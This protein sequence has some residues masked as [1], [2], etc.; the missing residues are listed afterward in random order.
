MDHLRLC[1]HIKCLQILRQVFRKKEKANNADRFEHNQIIVWILPRETWVKVKLRNAALLQNTA[2][3]SEAPAQGC[4]QS[5]HGVRFEGGGGLLP[6][7]WYQTASWWPWNLTACSPCHQSQG[8]AGNRLTQNEKPT[9]W[10]RRE[11]AFAW[12]QSQAWNKYFLYS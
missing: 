4:L 2:H 9:L 1:K 12:E 11:K 10:C 7:C 6:L 3:S 5:A 8:K